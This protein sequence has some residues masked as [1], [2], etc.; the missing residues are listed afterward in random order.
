MSTHEGITSPKL[1]VYRRVTDSIIT[2][3]DNGAAE[4]RMHHSPVSR[5]WQHASQRTTSA[6]S[7]S[8]LVARS[9]LRSYPPAASIRPGTAA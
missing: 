1:D 3:T 9:L 2:P 5:F 6:R 7:S 4:Y 8:D